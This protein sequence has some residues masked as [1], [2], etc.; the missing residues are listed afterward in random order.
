MKLRIQGNSMRIRLSEQEVQQFGQTGRVEE[1]VAFGPGPDQSLHY[2]LAWR[3]AVAAITVDFTGKAIMVY[4][5]E[6]AA[7]AWIG[8]SD[9]GLSGVVENGTA[10]GLQILVE[11]DLDCLHRD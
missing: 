4:I 5:P 11:K 3:E 2:V 6:S 7:A 10:Q 8:N 1:A 9:T